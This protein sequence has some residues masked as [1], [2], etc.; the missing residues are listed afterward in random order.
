MLL[1]WENHVGGQFDCVRVLKGFQ[2]I[3]GFS[4]GRHG[5]D[6]RRGDG[7]EDRE[8]NVMKENFLPDV[9]Q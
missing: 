5:D 7:A 6:T 8:L 3:A 1:F 4:K 2:P 9:M